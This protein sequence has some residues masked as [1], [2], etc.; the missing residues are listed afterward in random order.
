MEQWL[1]KEAQG[2]GQR[3]DEPVI[4]EAS[5]GGQRVP[6]PRFW[7]A[8]PSTDAS[9]DVGSMSLLAG[10]SVGL[11]DGVKPAADVIRELAEDVERIVHRLGG[12]I[13]P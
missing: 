7:A 1:G 13:R 3:A 2:Q 9:G 5:L 12:S 8:P 6:V 10:Q 11:V 4:G